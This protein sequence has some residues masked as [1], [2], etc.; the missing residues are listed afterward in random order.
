MIRAVTRAH[1]AVI[2]QRLEGP[3]RSSDIVIVCPRDFHYEPRDRFFIQRSGRV[4][5]QEML[6]AFL[7]PPSAGLDH[8]PY[9]FEMDF[10]HAVRFSAWI[11]QVERHATLTFT[12]DGNRKTSFDL[13]AGPGKGILW[14]EMPTG[15]QSVYDRE[16]GIR[17]PPG[18]HRVR[19]DNLGKGFVWLNA[20][21]VRAA[22][23][24]KASPA[25]RR[26]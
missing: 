24:S 13:P 26:P 12:L 25:R 1:R 4:E 10:D 19:V 15:W 16:L 17:V 23:A 11:Y 7:Q 9:T 5:G 6:R 21:T 2:G 14:K 8:Q 20:Y 18:R 3:K 22:A